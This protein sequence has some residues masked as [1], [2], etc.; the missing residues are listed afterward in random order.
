MNPAEEEEET[1]SECCLKNF[2]VETL[3]S[4][5]SASFELIIL[6]RFFMTILFKFSLS[7][8][9]EMDDVNGQV[10]GKKIPLQDSFS[11]AHEVYDVFWCN[12]YNIVCF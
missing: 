9:D 10:A 6:S 4:I 7:F 1:R 3:L 12:I 11:M 8:Q 5:S 2:Q